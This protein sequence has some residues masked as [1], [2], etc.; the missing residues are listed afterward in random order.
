MPAVDE[1]GF[2]VTEAE[3]SGSWSDLFFKLTMLYLVGRHDEE[4]YLSLLKVMASAPSLSRFA[5]KTH[6]RK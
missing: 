1:N 5:Y 6:Q 3:F 4:L 2:I